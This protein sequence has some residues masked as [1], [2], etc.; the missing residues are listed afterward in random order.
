[1]QG[2]L[3][4][5]GG[6]PGLPQPLAHLQRG[7]GDT[8]LATGWKLT[9]E[10]NFNIVFA[11]TKKYQAVYEELARCSSLLPPPSSLLPRQLLGRAHVAVLD[12]DGS[13][14]MDVV[15]A[16]F[17]DITTSIKVIPP[18]PFFPVLPVLP[19]SLPSLP[20]FLP[21][22]PSPLPP[23][24]PFL[25]SSLPSLPPFLPALPSPLPPCPPF[26]PS[27]LPPGGQSGV[28]PGGGGLILH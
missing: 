25:P 20:P 4:H 13:N 24:P 6:E 10:G 28:W 11:V 12:Q 16:G 18:A 1:M 22:L 2:G 9:Q 26:L 15:L 21:A 23:C 27:S 3:L 8:T 14:I 5:R 7:P 17:T 19:S